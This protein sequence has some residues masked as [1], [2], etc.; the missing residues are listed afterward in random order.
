MR[1]NISWLIKSNFKWL[2]QIIGKVHWCI[3]FCPFTME[4]Y[5]SIKRIIWTVVIFFIFRSFSIQLKL[6][7]W[8]DGCEPNKK[9]KTQSLSTE[10]IP[11]VFTQSHVVIIC[12]NLVCTWHM[13]WLWDN[14]R[15]REKN[16]SRMSGS[17]QKTQH[18]STLDKNT[19][20]SKRFSFWESV[21]RLADVI[22]ASR[23][24]CFCQK[25]KV[26]CVLMPLKREL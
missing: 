23:K 10:S 2:Y 14:T 15:E 22:E 4:L 19:F 5:L 25:L 17:G 12:G 20:P 13:A 7:R 9:E 21:L 18:G 16:K 24:F 8:R 6:N 26:Y 1:F 11:H 3:I